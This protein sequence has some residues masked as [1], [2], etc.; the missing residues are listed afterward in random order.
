M[1]Q[2]HDWPGNVRELRNFADRWVL[3]LEIAGG[4]STEQP[5]QTNLGA[6][7]D[8]FERSLIEAELRRAQGSVSRTAEALGV[9][10]KTLY[11]KLRKHALDA[12]A[13]RAAGGNTTV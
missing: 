1:W 7:V 5:A 12:D 3:G 4:G 2:A 11:D 10:R 8:A 9:P 6:H 13:Y